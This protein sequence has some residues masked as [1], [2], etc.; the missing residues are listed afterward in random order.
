[1][2]RFYTDSYLV[3]TVVSFIESNSMRF[4]STFSSTENFCS[5]IA[6]LGM[7]LSIVFP[8]FI[9]MI[10]S[11]K[12]Q[13]VDPTKERSKKIQLLKIDHQGTLSEQGRIFDLITD[14][15]L[16]MRLLKTEQH[17]KFCDSY[18][19]L[20]EGLRV[21]R[22]GIRLTVMTP[23]IDLLLKLLIAVSITR[24]VNWPIFSTF[25]FN[26]AILFN[27]EFILYFTP[28]D[29]KVRQ[30]QASFNAISFLLLNYHLL[31]F[32]KYTDSAMLPLVAN[33]VICFFWFC[34]SV[35]IL[36]TVP[37]QLLKAIIHLRK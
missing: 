25:I 34:I 32:S 21:E 24:L 7:V 37:I 1:M 4:G 8:L 28:Y 18:G 26:F 11:K 14:E 23:I 35:N 22:L 12:L 33:S 6:V 30:L 16:Q 31:L 10:Y 27:T 15:H 2:I 9:I 19:T 17:K 20:I 29:D 5:L 13:W 3:F 36:L